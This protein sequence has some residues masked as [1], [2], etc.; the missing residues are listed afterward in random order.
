MAVSYP[1][2]HHAVKLAFVIRGLLPQLI[3]TS[4]LTLTPSSTVNL[5]SES[6]IYL[7]FKFSPSYNGS[8]T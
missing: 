5:I 4:I 1:K 3:E 6:C 8:W 7:K 2:N